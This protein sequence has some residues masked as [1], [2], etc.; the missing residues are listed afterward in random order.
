MSAGIFRVFKKSVRHACIFQVKE[1]YRETLRHK[2]PLSLIIHSRTPRNRLPSRHRRPSAALAAS[3]AAA[4]AASLLL[5]T[6]VGWWIRAAPQS[7][8]DGTDHAHADGDPSRQ[9]LGLH[10]VR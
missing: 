9:P 6:A 3:T 4:A 5:L 7:L 1:F 2:P 10:R 8:L